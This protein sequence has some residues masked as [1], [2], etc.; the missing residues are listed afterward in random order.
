MLEEAKKRALRLLDRRDMSKK[1]LIDKLIEKGESPEDAHSAASRMEEL[2]LLSDERYA[3]MVARHYASKGYG[4]RRIEAELHRRGVPRPLWDAALQELPATENI[5]DRLLRIRLKGANPDRDTLKKACDAL[6][7]RG[8]SW[9]EI[10]AAAE[11]I[12]NES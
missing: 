12:K 5:V 10:Q 8:F 7:R 1:E 2:G 3:A 6:A 11:R 4:R 9:E